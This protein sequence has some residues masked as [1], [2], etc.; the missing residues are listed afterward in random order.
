MKVFIFM[1][2]LNNFGAPKMLMW[3]AKHL[4]LEGHQVTMYAFSYVKDCSIPSNVSFIHEN[5][6]G[7]GFLSKILHIRRMIKKADADVSISFLLDANVYNILACFGLKTKSVV[8][9]RNDPFKP[10]YYKLKF[11]KPLFRWAD[12]A[13]FQLE[14]AASYY[15][16]I[17]GK[18]AVIPN[19]I[20]IS[21]LDVTA[22]SG[23]RKKTVVTLGR[24][25]L[26]QKRQDILV[27]A[28]SIFQRRHPEYQL[29]IYGA[30]PD[31]KRICDLIEDLNIA[32]KVKMAGNTLTAQASIREAGMFVLSSDFEGIPNSLI[33]AMVIG[34]PCV[35]TD[36]SPGGARLLIRH[37]ENGLLSPVGNIEQLAAN[38]AWMAEHPKEAEKMG[39]EAKR[40]TDVF[41]EERIS[42]M[43]SEY[44]ETVV[45]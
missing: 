1:R 26:F 10:H 14:K 2:Y 21:G 45:S 16:N 17:K 7:K 9:E 40:I 4:A 30:G 29:I 37:H 31:E 13:V 33:E 39:Q 15:T 41:S 27:K 20:T 32:E 18:T 28:F 19:P 44:V 5:L 36:C 11:W 3:V 6:D 22:F 24:I 43:W 25:D 42:K 8:C 34:L 12:G 38:M 23:P 35:S